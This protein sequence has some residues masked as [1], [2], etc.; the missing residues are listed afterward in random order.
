MNTK[1]E[2]FITC[3]WK[4]SWPITKVLSMPD[5]ND[6]RPVRTIGPFVSEI[7]SG[8]HMGKNYNIINME[9]TVQKY[10]LLQLL[11]KHLKLKVNMLLTEDVILSKTK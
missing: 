3:R 8:H 7:E 6:G 4:R 9:D 11:Y 10:N 2:F 5:G 1:D